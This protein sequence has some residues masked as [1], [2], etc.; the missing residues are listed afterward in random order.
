MNGF[1][2]ESVKDEANIS[3]NFTYILFE[4]VALTLKNLKANPQL[5]ATFENAL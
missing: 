4:T 5:V 2:L 3:P 1:I